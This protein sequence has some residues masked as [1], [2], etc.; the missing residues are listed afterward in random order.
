M[1]SR[2]YIFKEDRQWL[3]KNLKEPNPT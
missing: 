1:S 2:Q 3:K